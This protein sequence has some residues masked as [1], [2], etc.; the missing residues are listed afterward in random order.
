MSVST[1]TIDDGRA[2][3]LDFCVKVRN[4]DPSILP[5][6]GKPFSIRPI[7]ERESIEL[8]DALL[9][10]T[11]VTYLE[12]EPERYTKISEEAMAKYVRT[13]KHLQRICWNDYSWMVGDRDLLH[14][15]EILC[16][17]LL[18]IQESTSLKELDIKL[19]L[20]G[21]P[22]DLAFESMLT[23]TQ[24]LR[25][26]TLRC[27]GHQEDIAVA[28][29]LSGLK[30]NTTLRELTLDR[31]PGAT[32]VSTILT[33]LRD[34]PLLRRLCLHGYLVDLTGLEAVLLSDDSKITELEIHD[35]EERGPVTPFGLTNVLR[36]LGRHPALT[37]LRL[38][39]ILLG[40]D[41][42]RLLRMILC[43]N[44]SLESLDLVRNN[45]GSAGLSEIAPA[46]CRNKSIKVLDISANMLGDME[47]VRLLR[48]MLRLNKN[49]TTLN[50]TGNEFGRSIECIADGLGSNSTL[51]GDRPFI[52]CLGRRRCF[53]S[54]ANSRLSEHNA[55]E[56]ECPV[57]FHY[58]YGRWR[59]FRNDG[60][61]QPPHH[62]SRPPTQRH[63]ERGGKSRS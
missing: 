57:Q 63:W 21:G 5:E 6:F 32:I 27:Y 24:S 53:H 35:E 59:A 28:A 48:D 45:L 46:L 25:S 50:L 44:P 43:N 40:R 60:T 30:K 61:E 18:A 7:R 19:P 23:H 38:K 39:D 41:E 15:E 34:H 20:S 56:A 58:I 31:K 4:N 17:I 51:N 49:M 36:A 13:S 33:S 55:T 62:G 1:G 16:C 54:G 14:R 10:N 47:S 11:N 42:A 9:E 37:K 2:T 26:L 52:L 8:S 12:L 29:A 3:F 22:S